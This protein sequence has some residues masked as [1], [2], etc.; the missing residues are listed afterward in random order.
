MITSVTKIY[1]NET[2]NPFEINV[3]IPIKKEV[4]FSKFKVELNNKIIISKILDQEKAEEKLSDA[5]AKGNLGIKSSYKEDNYSYI[6]NIGNLNPKSEVKIISE[7]IQ[8]LTNDDLS[9]SFSLMNYYL[10]SDYDN[11]KY[12]ININTHSKI[13][14]LIYKNLKENIIENSLKRKFNENQTNCNLNFIMKFNNKNEEINILFR[15]EK[16]N[17]KLLLKQYNPKLDETNYI[18][19]MIYNPIEIPKIEKIDL[20]ESINYFDKYGLNQINDNPSLFIFLIDQSYSM[21]GKPIQLVHESLLFFLHSL[22]NNSYFQLIGFGTRYKKINN[23]PLEYNKENVELTEKL[24][25]DLSADLGGTNI[26][27][28]LKDIFNSNDYDNIKLSKNLL[29]LTDGEVDN[30]E[31]CLNLISNNNEQFKIHSIGIG[32]SFD[33][34]LIKK[35]GVYGKGSFNF[36]TNI[37]DINS[38]IIQ[39]LNKCLKPYL[40]DT[41]FNLISDKVEYQFIPKY[42]IYQDE[43]LN[44][45]FIQKGKKNNKVEI[46]FTSTVNNESIKENFVF[47]DKKII[48]IPN[49]EILSKIIIGNILKN[50]NISKEEE[51]ELSKKYQILSKNTS[52]F[53][54]ISGNEPKIIG[55]LKNIKQNKYSRKYEDYDDDDCCN[56]IS[57]EDECMMEDDGN[58]I[59]DCGGIVCDEDLSCEDECMI[60]DEEDINHRAPLGEKMCEKDKMCDEKCYDMCE[61]ERKCEPMC[62]PNCNNKYL[63]EKIRKMEEEDELMMKDNDIGIINK[64]ENINNLNIKEITLTQDSYDGF[65]ELNPS[66]QLII[67]KNKDIFDKVKQYVNSKNCI[68]E[69]VIITFVMIYF[70]KNEK[71]INQSEYVLILNKG[72]KFLRENKF[73]YE[74]ILNI[75]SK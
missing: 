40:I 19:N 57:C 13:T 58:D 65:W 35:A 11:L 69:R 67:D 72:I 30:S 28:P 64:K 38:V 60:D 53:A 26:S 1:K 17:E 6:L 22:P 9:Y 43:I 8:F 71:T 47:D 55:T 12:N 29:I 25:K 20:D 66:T 23:I 51:I 2:D 45:S 42:I 73:D 50:K 68:D 27:D 36:V 56:G 32:D 62:E 74:E 39:N 37:N 49:G 52:L 21:S 54:E 10:L 7:F 34:Y 63:E 24:I 70:L 61:P 75:I 46:E 48:N 3:I 15:T 44:Y 4:Q 16:M 31:E 14:R 5:V 33:E 41:N 18:M 59:I